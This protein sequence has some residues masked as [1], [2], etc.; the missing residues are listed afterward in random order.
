MKSTIAFVLFLFSVVLGVYFYYSFNK[1]YVISKEAK[2]YYK[3]GN[4]QEAY[5]LAKKAYEEDSYNRQAST[6]MVHSKE[7]K[8]WIDFIDESKRFLEYM[9]TIAQKEFIE[10]SELARIKMMSEITIE[11]FKKLNQKNRLIDDSLKRTATKIHQE[12]VEVYE[13]L[14]K[15]Q[16]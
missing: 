11:K 3:Q 9:Q 7:S 6:L 12:I 5:A 13:K 16:E 8:N 14:F 10:D 2:K 15:N 1:S 4:F